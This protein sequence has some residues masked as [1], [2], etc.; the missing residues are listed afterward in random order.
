MLRIFQAT[1]RAR[2]A[3]ANGHLQYTP[4]LILKLARVIQPAS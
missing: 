4:A 2:N 3:D 1:R